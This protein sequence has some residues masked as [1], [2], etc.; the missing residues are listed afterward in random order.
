[1]ANSDSSGE[2]PDARTLA[3]ALGRAADGERAG[4]DEVF[5]ATYAELKHLAR[6]ARRALRG[7][8]LDT[9][10]I[11]HECYLRLMKSPLDVDSAA[12]FLA[13]AA[14]AMRFVLIEQARE[15]VSAKRGGAMT[16][17]DLDE[18]SLAVTSNA[19]ELIEIDDLVRRLAAVDSRQAQ[20]V[21]CRYFAGLS[22]SE[23][24][25]ALGISLRSVQR[26]WSAARAWMAANS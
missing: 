17:D 26:D 8:T 25:A 15:R 6:S 12:H 10:G 11:V 1:M 16:H 20:I 3:R 13:I 4:Y 19:Q 7:G 9:T 5:A 23:T 22:E 14:R 24:A 2:D 18:T 21:E